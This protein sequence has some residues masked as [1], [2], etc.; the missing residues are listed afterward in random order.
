[1][2]KNIAIWSLALAIVLVFA[3]GNLHA[4]AARTTY[5]VVFAHGMAGFDDLPGYDYWGDDYGT[6]VGDPC[7]EFLE[8]SCDSYINAGQMAFAAQVQPFQSSEVRGIARAVTMT[9]L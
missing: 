5:P 7:N 8:V 4:G 3:A 6:F 2:R 1:M 9:A